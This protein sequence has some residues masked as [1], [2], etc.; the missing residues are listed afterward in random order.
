MSEAPSLDFSRK[1]LKLLGYAIIAATLGV[2]IWAVLTL[3]T[4]IFGQAKHLRCQSNL[5]SIIG[6][7]TMYRDRYN[8]ELPPHLAVLLPFL[9]GRYDKFQCP[10]DPNGGVKG[11][12]PAW[13]KRYDDKIGD[14]AFDNVDLDGPSL[15][16]EKA[17]D[18]FPCSYLYAANGYPCGFTNFETTWR[19]EFEKLVRKHGAEVPMIRCYY[20]LPERYDREAKEPG[21][22]DPAVSPTYNVTLEN[23]NSAELKIREYPLLWQSMPR[24]SGRK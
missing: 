22:P 5:K 20:H 13:L 17:D 2:V 18:S 21:T 4:A 19:Q 24:F 9:D 6:A 23:L 10:A 14:G 7:M 15:D 8:G 11:C 12:R 1:F 3:G 16:P